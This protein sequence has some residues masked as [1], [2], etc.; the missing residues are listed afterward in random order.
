M[1]IP[2]SRI[3]TNL[4]TAGG[5]YVIE[6]ENNSYVGYYY[7][8]YDGKLFTGKTPDDKPNYVLITLDFSENNNSESNV[9]NTSIFLQ[10]GL[11]VY[12]NSLED[13]NI[14]YTQLKNT[15]LTSVYYSPKLYLPTPTEQD[16]K[17]GEF[18]RYFCKKRNEYIYLEISKEDYDKLVKRDST[19]DYKLWFPFNIPWLLVGDKNKVSQVNKDIVLLQINKDKLYGFNKYLKEDYLKYYKV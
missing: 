12:I 15:S 3:Q 2:K 10:E 9:L 7:K 13:E 14:T 8:T 11:S 1:Y 19:I 18:R 4:Y 17:L 6:G 16:Y 5:E